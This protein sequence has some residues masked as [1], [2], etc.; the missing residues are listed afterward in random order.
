MW[1]KVKVVE[2]W[3]YVYAIIQ[4]LCGWSIIRK[5]TT[6]ISLICFSENNDLQDS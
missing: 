2:L 4:I 3:L 5:Y 1:M 6:N